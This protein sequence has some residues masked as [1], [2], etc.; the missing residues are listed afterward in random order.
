[1]F[2]TSVFWSELPV[3]VEPIDEYVEPPSALYETV[4]VLI[5]AASMEWPFVTT[6]AK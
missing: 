2:S 6:P 4:K 1:M 3:N 5:Q